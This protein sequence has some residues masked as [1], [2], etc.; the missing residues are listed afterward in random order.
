MKTCNYF[1]IAHSQMYGMSHG[2]YTGG[3]FDNIALDDAKEIA[4]SE[5][6]DIV[7]GY[8][9]IMSDIYDSLNED[10]GYDETPENPEGDYLDAL[11]DAIQ[12]ECAYFIWEITPEG[13]EHWDAMEEDCEFYKDFLRF[14]WII[15]IN[16]SR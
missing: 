6:Y 14:G 9:C 10:F 13:E 15:P 7:T 11:E 8:L 2:M 16:E 4:F 1:Y 3:C 12:E 5:A